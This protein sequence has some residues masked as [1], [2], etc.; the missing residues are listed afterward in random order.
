MHPRAHAGLKFPD[1]SRP[2]TL[3]RKY[4]GKLPADA[5]AFMRSLLS[6]DSSQRLTCAQVIKW[7][8]LHK[9][10]FGDFLV[11]H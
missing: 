9:F 4:V 8:L 11:K 5:H 2:E 1:M 10:D 7:F 6:L 3:E